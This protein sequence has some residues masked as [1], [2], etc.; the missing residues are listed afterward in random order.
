M[1]Q[2]VSYL[3]GII[4]PT[5]FLNYFGQLFADEVGEISLCLHE[6]FINGMGDKTFFLS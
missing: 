1:S 5:F 6:Y 4:I 3:V 2:A